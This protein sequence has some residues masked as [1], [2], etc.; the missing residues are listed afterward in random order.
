MFE[1]LEIA[2]GELRGVS[3]D[4]IRRNIA[5]SIA[6]RAAIKI[7]MRLDQH[8]DGLAVEGA[9]GNVVPDELPA[10][11]ADRAALPD[12]GD[13]ESFPPHLIR[14]YTNPSS[15][16]SDTRGPRCGAHRPSSLGDR[17]PRHSW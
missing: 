3:M 14:A 17:P 5:A 6:C 4:D 12:A 1:I 16:T 7:N 15:G 2:E 13:P 9:G 10:R 11:P 8:K